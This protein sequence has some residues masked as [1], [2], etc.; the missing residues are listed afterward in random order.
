MRKGFTAERTLCEFL[1]E[2]LGEDEGISR[3]GELLAGWI[4]SELI[5][6]VISD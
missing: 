3:A 2:R 1:V 6:G 5:V 4:G